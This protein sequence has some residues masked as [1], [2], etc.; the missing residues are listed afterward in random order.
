MHQQKRD[1]VLELWYVIPG[2]AEGTGNSELILITVRA[3]WSEN[4]LVRNGPT[5]PFSQI[6]STLPT[7]KNLQDHP[8]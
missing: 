5:F 1:T 3:S 6:P 4:D 7:R 2:E 8:D